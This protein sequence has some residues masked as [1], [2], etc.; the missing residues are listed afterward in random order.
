MSL[1]LA[2][3]GRNGV[4]LAA[5]SRGTIGDPRGLTAINDQHQKLFRLSCH[6][7][8]CM[9]GASE[10]GTELI[11]IVQSVLNADRTSERYVDGAADQLRCI[12]RQM[13]DDWFAKI[14]DVTARPATG[15]IVGGIR[16]DG[17]PRIVLLPSQ[18]DFAPTAAAA[19]F[20]A[21]GVPQYATYLVH[22][23]YDRSK[24]VS[25]LANLAAYLID[26]T[27]SQDPKVGGLVRLATV[28][29]SEGYKELSDKEVAAIR[30]T[31]QK[32]TAAIKA[33]F[34]GGGSHGD[35]AG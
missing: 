14:P 18:F 9:F 28:T 3:E 13:Y 20:M 11:R 25:D 34:Y 30:V 6:A 26:E 1:A 24:D 19:G 22:R 32:Q 4:A 21:G 2:L 29:A 27:A 17:T 15:F 33:L 12:A 23:F 10:V 35:D 8:V 31:N 16:E 5:D 7:G